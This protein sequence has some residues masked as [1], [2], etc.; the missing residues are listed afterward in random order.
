MRKFRFS[1]TLSVTKLAAIAYEEEVNHEGISQLAELQLG[2]MRV[3]L[4][5]IP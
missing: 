4:K 3:S 5:L 1:S 2:T